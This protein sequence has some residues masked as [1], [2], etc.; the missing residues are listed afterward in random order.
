MRSG[1]SR[2]RRPGAAAEGGLGPNRVL[3]DH[4]GLVRHIV[5]IDRGTAAEIAAVQAGFI[6]YKKYL[7][8]GIHTA[9]S[10]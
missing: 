7:G 10:C 9:G 3:N 2:P 5:Y 6:Q 1:W 8:Y 4:C